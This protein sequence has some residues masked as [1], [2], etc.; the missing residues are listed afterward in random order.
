MIWKNSVRCLKCRKEYANFPL[1][2]YVG[3]IRDEIIVSKWQASSGIAAFK[4]ESL[5]NGRIISI[6]C[7]CCILTILIAADLAPHTLAGYARESQEKNP[8]LQMSR[9]FELQSARC[10]LK[11]LPVNCPRCDALITAGYMPNRCRY[12]ESDQ[13][14]IFKAGPVQ[15][16]DELSKLHA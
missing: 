13:L 1:D 3:P 10:K 12:C 16:D 4:C 2:V 6:R 8:D 7:P 15:Q 9:I 14:Q 11:E 5:Y